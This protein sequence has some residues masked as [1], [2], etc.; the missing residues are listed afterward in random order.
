LT[1]EYIEPTHQS[2]IGLTLVGLTAV[3]IAFVLFHFGPAFFQPPP[4][5]SVCETLAHYRGMMQKGSLLLILPGLWLCFY[6]G[7]I[8]RSG[9]S[10]A[11]GAWVLH[12]AVIKTGPH[13]TRVGIFLIALGIIVAVSPMYFWSDYSQFHKGSID[14]ACTGT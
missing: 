7:R 2:Q 14:L 4:T 11:P 6:A 10:P 3:C 13:V 1:Q 5:N 12:R 8:L 9:Q